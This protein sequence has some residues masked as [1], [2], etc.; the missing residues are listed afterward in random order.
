MERIEHQLNIGLIYLNEISLK[1]NHKFIMLFYH[2]NI[3]I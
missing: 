3:Y 1:F 2:L